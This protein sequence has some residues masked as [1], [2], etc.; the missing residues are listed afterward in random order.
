MPRSQSLLY[1]W[2][3]FKSSENGFNCSKR[4]IRDLWGFNFVDGQLQIFIRDLISRFFLNLRNTWNL[5]PTKFNP[6]KVRVWQSGIRTYV[7]IWY[8]DFVQPT[9]VWFSDH[10]RQ[11]TLNMLILNTFCKVPLKSFPARILKF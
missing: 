4:F 1:T 10:V 2:N 5:I 8:E 11:R 6:L 3:F 9:N 7:R